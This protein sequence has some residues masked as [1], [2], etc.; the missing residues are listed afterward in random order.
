VTPVMERALNKAVGHLSVSNSEMM[1]MLQLICPVLAF[2]AVVV[3]HELGHVIAGKLAGFR[4]VSINFGQ[5]QITPPLHFKWQRKDPL[6]GALGFVQHLPV[7]TKHLRFR[8]MVAYFGGPAANLICAFAISSFLPQPAIFFAWFALLSLFTGI[9]NLL[10]FSQGRVIPDGRHIL[11]LLRNQHQKYDQWLAIFQLVHD[12]LEGAEPEN[13]RPDF[14]AIATAV[15][16]NSLGTVFGHDIAY[17][18]AYYRHDDE[19]AARLL[20]ICLQYSGCAPQQIRENL[21]GHAA[22]FQ[23]IRRKRVDL[24]RQ[25]L[26]DIP[27]KTVGPEQRPTIEAYL[28]AGEGD[29]QGAMKKLDEAE[30]LHKPSEPRLQKLF[31][32]YQ[33]KM[34]QDLTSSVPVN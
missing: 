9:G 25:W 11:M 17:T 20:E 26:A 29:L 23:A 24:G 4:L 22:C 15:K 5:L 8:E 34:R 18:A 12:Q 1:T 21:F 16:E 31:L 13:L 27:E 19:E 30:A 10:P 6:P 7:Y 32:R 33:Q 3:V 14:L 2:L 28:L